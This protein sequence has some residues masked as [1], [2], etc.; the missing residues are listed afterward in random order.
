ME[1]GLDRLSETAAYQYIPCISTTMASCNTHLKISVYK[2][3]LKAVER[4][5]GKGSSS[6]EPSM[7]TAGFAKILQVALGS[8]Q[9]FLGLSNAADERRI[10]GADSTERFLHGMD[11]TRQI[12]WKCFTS[13][14]SC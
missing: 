11:E 6:W 13:V 4:G 12:S 10:Y 9:D 2:W 14:M 3:N 5:W 7:A 1:D 8:L